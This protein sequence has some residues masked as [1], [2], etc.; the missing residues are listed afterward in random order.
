MVGILCYRA[1]D[2]AAPQGGQPV[3]AMPP[4]QSSNPNNPFAAGGQGA[5]GYQANENTQLNMQGQPMYTPGNYSIFLINLFTAMKH[6]D[7]F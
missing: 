6:L 1:G 2:G 7:T 4:P 3:F 5:G